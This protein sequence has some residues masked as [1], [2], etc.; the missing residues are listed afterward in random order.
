MLSVSLAHS[1]KISCSSWNQWCHW[2]Q[3]VEEPQT[4]Y[5]T[6][7]PSCSREDFCSVDQNY[8]TLSKRNVQ[9]SI[10]IS[11]ML[12][13]KKVLGSVSSFCGVCMFSRVC[14]GTLR[15]FRLFPTVQRRA[16]SKTNSSW[17]LISQ[18]SHS[19]ERELPVTSLYANKLHK[20]IK[21]AKSTFILTR[22]AVNSFVAQQTS[23]LSLVWLR[24]QHEWLSFSTFLLKLTSAILMLL[25]PLRPAYCWAGGRG[26]RPVIDRSRTSQWGKKGKCAFRCFLKHFFVRKMLKY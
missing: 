21:Y 3:E 20:H 13:S 12:Q 18:L 19:A 9:L 5:P 7:L 15:V 25:L 16:N 24:L 14:M 4:V 1:F 10:E 6:S 23:R 17:W 2:F 26:M 22:L 11:V 8:T